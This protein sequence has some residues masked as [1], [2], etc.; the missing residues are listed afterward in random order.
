M[1]DLII[2]VGK[3]EIE[4]ISKHGK[5]EIELIL[6]YDIT[7]K[8]L[9]SALAKFFNNKDIELDCIIADKEEEKAIIV[10]KGLLNSKNKKVSLKI[11][12][13]LFLKEYIE[14]IKAIT[15]KGNGES[16]EIFNWEILKNSLDKFITEM[17]KEI[18]KTRSK[19]IFL[20]K[21]LL[22]EKIR[23]NI[24]AGRCKGTKETIKSLVLGEL[25]N[26]IQIEL[27]S[28]FCLSFQEIYNLDTFEAN[29]VYNLLRS[30]DLKSTFF[31]SELKR[32]VKEFKEPN[33]AKPQDIYDL[34]H[35]VTQEYT[36]LILN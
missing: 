9:N 7:L 27:D 19:N 35:Q 6:L 25:L 12:E 2:A 22:I 24:Q 4:K 3:R 11:G 36:E 13:I 29:L 17:Y 16:W 10:I 18:Y 32:K 1:N 14:Q 26:K 23:Y 34:I 21:S 31:L 20:E 8:V 15:K 30:A 28:N 5:S 33:K